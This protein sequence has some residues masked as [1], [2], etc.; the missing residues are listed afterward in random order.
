MKSER[1]VKLTR[2]ER[3]RIGSCL[4]ARKNYLETLRQNEN[5]ELDFINDMAREH[6]NDI[7]K[8]LAEIDD[9]YSKIDIFPSKPVD[10]DLEELSKADLILKIKQLEEKNKELE[11]Q[12]EELQEENRDLKEDFK[13]S[14]SASTF[15]VASFFTNYENIQRRY[16]SNNVPYQMQGTEDLAKVFGLRFESVQGFYNLSE[17]DKEIFKKGIVNFLNA[18]GLGNRVPYLPVK[19]WKDG[20]EFRFLTLE[21]GERQQFMN[22][23]G[24]VY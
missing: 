4:L 23:E 17:E 7:D 3:F 15:E 1:L 21:C 14:E 10:A 2:S 13:N 22:A 12:N 6:N 20:V 8:E 5:T 18:H 11:Y 24:V 9:I 19:V 16:D